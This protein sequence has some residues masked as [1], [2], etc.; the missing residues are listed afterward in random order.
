MCRISAA[1]MLSSVPGSLETCSN[2]NIDQMFFEH[3]RDRVV[4]IALNEVQS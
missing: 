2:V 4:D 1:E 3:F